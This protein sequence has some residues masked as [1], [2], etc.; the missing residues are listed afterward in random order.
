VELQSSEPGLELFVLYDPALANTCT[1]DTGYSRGDALIAEEG[2]V[3]TALVASP[4]FSRLSTGYQGRSDGRTDLLRNRR[5][6]RLFQRAEKGNIL[7]VGQLPAPRAGGRF[8][9]ALGFGARADEALS[10]ARAS[11]AAGFSAVRAAYVAEWQDYLKGLRSPADARYRLPVQRAAMVLRAHEDK[12]YRGAVI[13]SMSIPWGG[14]IRADRPDIGGYHLVW[15]RDLYQVAT[16]LLALGDRAAAERALDYLFKVQQRPDGTYPQNSWLHGKPYWTSLQMD[17]IAFPIVMAWQLG[18]KDAVTWEKHVRPSAEYLVKHG[19]ATPQERW[20]EEAGYSPSTI[21]AEIAG[22][23][24]A[25]EIAEAN[26]AARDAA[27]YRKTADG[28]AASLEKWL[29]TRTGKL[30]DRLHGKGYYLRIND[31]QNPDDGARLELNNGGGTWDERE[32][33]DAGFLEL[34]RLGIRPPEDPWIARSLEVIDATIKVETPRG[35]CWYRYNHDGYGEKADGSGYDGTGIGRLW[36]LLAGERGEYEVARGGDAQPYLKA[37]LAFANQGEMLP[38]QVWD[39]PGPA[40]AGFR[41]GA[42]TDSATPLAW[43][44]AQLIRLVFS[45]EDRKVVELPEVV[46]A[47]YLKGRRQARPRTR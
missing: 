20:E 31:N 33:V 21:A 26:R 9:L 19:P 46:A 15:S 14:R 22:L 11:L 37:L 1:G 34:V 39:R 40:P 12:T 29:V 32:V 7:Q 28:W 24:C 10:N 44:E 16:A 42:G 17:E 36:P 5:L 45:V 8:T 47:R 27:R 25:A 41:F 23:V 4:A 38:E 18:R 6:T 3:A 35:P 2:K 13:A 30:D 43:T